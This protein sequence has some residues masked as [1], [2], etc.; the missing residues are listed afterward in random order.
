MDFFYS[1]FPKF[2]ERFLN[3][4]K[5]QTFPFDFGKIFLDEDELLVDLSHLS[6]VIMTGVLAFKKATDE[7]LKGKN[8]LMIFVVFQLAQVANYSFFIAP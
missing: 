4:A 7:W 1:E 2:G 8:R 3:D 5:V 6:Y